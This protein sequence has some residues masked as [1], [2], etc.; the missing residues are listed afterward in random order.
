MAKILVLGAGGGV[1]RTFAERARQ[2]RID[3]APAFP[4]AIEL[5]GLPHSELDVTVFAEVERVVFRERPAVVVYAAGFSDLNACEWDKWQAYL[6][7]RDAAGQAARACAKAGAVFVYF[8]T[9]LLFD[10]ARRTPY[11]EEDPPT[12]VNVYADT[13]LAGELDVMTHA[14]RYLIVRT[15]WLYGAHFRGPVAS[16]MDRLRS[17]DFVF[18]TE[19]AVR[20]PTWADELIDATCALLAKGKTGTWHLAAQGGA[21]ELDVAR[22]VAALLRPSASAQPLSATTTRDL[23][24]PYSVLDCSKA[25]DEGVAL[26]KWEESLERYVRSIRGGDTKIGR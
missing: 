25:A 26:P 15:G 2:G 23:L 1:G 10:G 11:R 12:P 24:S 17:E 18:G 6:V 3:L 14:E 21:T 4:G 19:N 8:G 22:R 20:Q 9:D 5:L 7:N 16:L 13:K